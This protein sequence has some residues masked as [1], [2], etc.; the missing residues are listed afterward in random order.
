[1]KRTYL[2]FAVVP[3]LVLLA[4]TIIRARLEISD[5]D[6]LLTHI[7]SVNYPTLVILVLWPLLMMAQGLSLKQYAAVMALLLLLVRL[8]IAVVYTMAYDQGWTVEATGEPVRYILQVTE[9][10]AEPATPVVFLGTF[11]FPFTA[12]LI[13]SI[14][15]WSLVW[16]IG[17]RGRRPFAA[18]PA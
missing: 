3:G 6:A 13:S 1:M 12:I 2:V 11:F 10:G 16:L 18:A 9:G 8:P 4:V 15:T 14:I 17:Y 5:P 7:V